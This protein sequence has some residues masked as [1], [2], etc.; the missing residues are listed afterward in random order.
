MNLEKLKRIA[1]IRFHSI[2]KHSFIFNYKLRIILI[3]ESYI[4]IN[5][6]R[7]VKDKYGFHWELKNSDEIYRVDNFPDIKWKIVS[8]YPHHFHNGS[9]DNVISS[10]FSINIE[11]GFIEFMTFVENR[12]STK[13]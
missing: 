4:D 6:S 2:V 1:D 3:D 12:L 5:L 10:P 11:Q 7:R 13:E 8:T 9:Q